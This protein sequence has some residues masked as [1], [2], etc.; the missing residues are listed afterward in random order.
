MITISLCMIVKNEEQILDR[1]LLS[2]IN[3]VDE[4]IILDTGST[5]RTK[6]IARNYT[7]K[8]YDFS[9]TGSFSDA[10]NASFSYATMDYIYC[11][12]A[13]EMIDEVNQQLFLQMK[14][15]LLPEIEIVQMMYC[16]QL[17]NNTTYN[18]DKEYRPK[19]FKRIREFVW[20]YPIHEQI[21]LTPVIYDSEIEIIHLPMELHTQRDLSMFEKMTEDDIPINKKLLN[22]YAREL[23]I[24][25]SPE[26]FIR[27]KN[28]FEQTILEETRDDDEIMESACILAKC[29]LIEQNFSDFFKYTLKNIAKDGCSES[30]YELGNYYFS[31]KD[32]KEATIWYYNAAFETQSILNIKTSAQL[33]LN[34]LMHCC[35][36]LGLFE[37]AA[38]YETMLKELD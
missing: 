6:E 12:D 35:K 24:S 27:A 13:D 4:I 16:N 10:R 15:T 14:K 26:Q 38:L 2:L 5:D 22:M 30:C 21:R 25:G 18:F 9:W 37:Q 8:V 32:Y 29:A 7:D 34:G 28:T 17:S 3:L 31:Q 19:L 23:Y 33:P 36:E 20:E 11:A 1:C